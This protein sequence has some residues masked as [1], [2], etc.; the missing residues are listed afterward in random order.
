MISTSSDSFRKR[1]SQAEVSFSLPLYIPR[2]TAVHTQHSEE[3]VHE[4]Q[5]L[6]SAGIAAF[7]FD[8]IHVCTALELVS[9]LTFI[10]EK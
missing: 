6:T 5:Q 3:I 10:L 9:A 8:Q 1:L 2:Q 7:V 4:M